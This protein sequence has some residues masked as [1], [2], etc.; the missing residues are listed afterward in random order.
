MRPLLPLLPV[1]AL[2]LLAGCGGEKSA[3]E[4]NTAGLDRNAA[5]DFRGAIDHYQQ[6]LTQAAGDESLELQIRRNIADARI[7][8]DAT[9]AAENF[10][11]LANEHPEAIT[12]RDYL[13]FGK[14]LQDAGQLS[15]AVLVVTEGVKRFGKEQ[16]PKLDQLAQDLARA[17]AASG[18][19][20]ADAMKA[21]EGLG[22]ISK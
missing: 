2:S 5:G 7:H 13:S 11:D 20:S 12:D 17:L 6:A 3:V 21:L 1:L 10:L 16:A 15:Q 19:A 22:Y 9:A 14:Q 8:L 4:L 18:D